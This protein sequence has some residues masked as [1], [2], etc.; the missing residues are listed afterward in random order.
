MVTLVVM[1][2]MTM[3]A[4]RCHVIRCQTWAAASEGRVS[5]KF[6]SS[7]AP[8]NDDSND[9][10]EDDEDEDEE[11]FEALVSTD[12]FSCTWVLTQICGWTKSVTE[13]SSQG[14][15]AD[16]TTP[17]SSKS[18]FSPQWP[19]ITTAPNTWNR[20]SIF[21]PNSTLVISPLPAPPVPYLPFTSPLDFSLLANPRQPPGYSLFSDSWILRH[22]GFRKM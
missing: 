9:G 7:Y 1:M 14:P 5:L 16:N 6:N 15:F 8:P 21:H 4:R 11:C 17:R 18:V 3:K 22:T 12:W 19:G 20:N 10:D 13:P 2:T